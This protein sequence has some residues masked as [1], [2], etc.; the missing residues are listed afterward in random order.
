M[1]DTLG[2]YI[3]G[4]RYNQEKLSTVYSHMLKE[5][6]NTIY[7]LL[8]EVMFELHKLNHQNSEIFYK[9]DTLLGLDILKTQNSYE[10]FKTAPHYL[11]AFLDFV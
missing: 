3:C 2:M 5:L 11:I 8:P 9:S 7:L 6:T 10:A 4:C 1:K